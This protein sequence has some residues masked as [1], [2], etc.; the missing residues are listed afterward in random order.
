MRETHNEEEMS[1]KTHP[2][3]GILP[4]ASDPGSG[5]SLPVFNDFS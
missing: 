2:K 1:I 5:Q 4:S 3:T